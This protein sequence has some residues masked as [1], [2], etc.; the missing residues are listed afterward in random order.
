MSP[1]QLLF[2]ASSFVAATLASLSC[3]G[4]EEAQPGSMAQRVHDQAIVV[5][6]HAHP[7]PGNPDSLNLGEQAGTYELDFLTM[8]EGGLDAVFFSAPILGGRTGGPTG[9]DR[10]MEDL[11]SIVEEVRRH[12]DL[13]EVALSSGDIRRSHSL[14]KRAV[15]LAI[16]AADPFEGDVDVL[17]GYFDA[18]VRMVTLPPEVLLGSEAGHVDSLSRPLSTLGLGVVHQMNR[19]GMVIDISHLYDR[20]QMDVI[21]ASVQPVVAS[22]SCARALNDIPRELPDSVI[23]ALSE[24]GGVVGVTFYPGHISSD[25]ESR[26]VTVE[27]LVD[28]IDHIVRVAGVNHVGFGSDFLGSDVHTVG[29]ESAA[30]LPNL[31]TALLE[32]GYSPGDIE[33]ILGGNLLRVLEGVEEGRGTAPDQTSLPES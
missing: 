30:G 29:L 19:L 4:G 2:L 12:G 31:T 8:G 13:A 21:R 15:L 6:A 5:D 9:P 14:G 28:H 18:G 16:E 24:K 25:F 20:Q 26:T 10:L 17:E 32:R 1:H 22:H 23:R 27:D 11:E 7:R 33:K 3:T